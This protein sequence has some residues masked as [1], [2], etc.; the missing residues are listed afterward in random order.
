MNDDFDDAEDLDDIDEIDGD[1]GDWALSCSAFGCGKTE[2]GE[3]DL[4]PP[5]DDGPAEF[6]LGISGQ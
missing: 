2:F 1:D 5:L 4:L 6:S 3:R